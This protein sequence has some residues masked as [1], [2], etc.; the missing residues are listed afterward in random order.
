M[1]RSSRTT[2]RC[3]TAT[4]PKGL[5]SPTSPTPTR[6]HALSSSKTRTACSRAPS[7][8]SSR[9]W[10]ARATGGCF[11]RSAASRSTS[12]APYR[13]RSAA[14]TSSRRRTRFRTPN[15]YPI[16][17]AGSRART[18][19]SLSPAPRDA[20]ALDGRATQVLR[21]ARPKRRRRAVDV[22][23]RHPRL[24]RIPGRRRRREHP[25]GRGPGGRGPA[26]AARRHARPGARAHRR[27]QVLMR[28]RGS[29]FGFYASSCRIEQPALL[30]IAPTLVS[31]YA[32]EAA[33]STVKVYVPFAI[34][35]LGACWAHF[36][37]DH[38]QLE[39]YC[40]PPA[41]R[42]RHPSLAP[43]S[44][45]GRADGVSKARARRRAHASRSRSRTASMPR[46][47]RSSSRRTANKSCS[48]SERPTRVTRGSDSKK[49]STRDAVDS[50]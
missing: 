46:S 26:A 13:R 43:A 3:L 39:A 31:D 18:N 5:S 4:W 24:G 20:A 44:R 23:G 25:R 15:P 7:Q 8:R 32:F 49:T 22:G 1:G 27:A 34:D 45:R 21:A 30:R 12:S 10:T 41:P 11:A 28:R 19:S 14:I 2:R 48:G 33:G 17:G 40:E 42:R 37:D 50:A 38:C 36:E 29:E 9:T 47:R 16:G 6:R 35:A